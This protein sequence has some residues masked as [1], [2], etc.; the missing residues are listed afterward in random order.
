MPR[1]YVPS[2]AMWFGCTSIRK[3]AMNKRDGGQLW[4]F[5]PKTT[6][7]N[8]ASLCSALSRI[9]SKA[10]RLRRRSA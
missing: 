1:R 10:I 5:R 2:A 6:I 7:R 8:P 3:Q 9:K 4:C